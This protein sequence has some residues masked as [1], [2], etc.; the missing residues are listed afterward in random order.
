M[1]IYA[2]KDFFHLGSAVVIKQYTVYE[3]WVCMVET[4][5]EYISIGNP[6]RKETIW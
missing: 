6:Q 3:L 4:V 5:Y 2:E 1:T